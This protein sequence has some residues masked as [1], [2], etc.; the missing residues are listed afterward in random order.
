MWFW[1]V[2]CLSCGEGH[3][4]PGPFVDSAGW[5]TE[6]NCLEVAKEF[7]F[8]MGNRWSERYGYRCTTEHPYEPVRIDAGGKPRQ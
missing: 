4:R 3:P 7:A 2:V 8:N 6:R 5:L 1:I